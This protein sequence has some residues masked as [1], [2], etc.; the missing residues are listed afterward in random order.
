M[1]TKVR[2]LNFGK[3]YYM[4]EKFIVGTMPKSG[5]PQTLVAGIRPEAWKPENRDRLAAELAECLEAN[6]DFTAI[7]PKVI[8]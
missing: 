5:E 7:E 1:A 6:Q 3:E 2:C 8:E 4:S